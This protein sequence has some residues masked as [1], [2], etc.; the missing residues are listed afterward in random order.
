MPTLAI[1]NVAL[2]A[3][4]LVFSI[5]LVNAKTGR[6]RAVFCLD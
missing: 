2:F 6:F 4:L 3:G 1:V 5:N